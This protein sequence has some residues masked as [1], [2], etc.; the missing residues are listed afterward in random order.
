MITGI[1]AD[2]RLFFYRW[3]QW[4]CAVMCVMKDDDLSEL[5]A[6]GGGSSKSSRHT[7]VIE[8]GERTQPKR[9]TLAD[10]I[11]KLFSSGDFIIADDPSYLRRTVM[12][13]FALLTLGIGATFVVFFVIRLMEIYE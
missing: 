5:Q 9:K 11:K 7:R 8:L 2:L 12:R 1:R 4:L 3:V 6:S 13:V 10:T